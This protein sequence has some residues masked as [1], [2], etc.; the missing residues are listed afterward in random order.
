MTGAGGDAVLRVEDVSHA[1]GSGSE[2]QQVLRDVSFA[3]E[4]G[5]T[6]AVVGESGAGKST[7]SRLVAGLERPQRG[8]IEVEG[9]PTAIRAGRVS[10]VQMAF[11]HPAEALNR[12]ASVG[13]SVQEPL[14]TL[15]RR[16]RH[17]R[18]RELLTQVGIDPGRAGDRP[19]AFSGGQLQRIVLARALVA[20]PALLLCDEPTSA[21]DVSVQ[22]QI[23]NL[24]LRLQAER[25]FACLLVTHD[26]G[27]AKVLCDEVLVLKDGAVVEHAPADAFFAGPQ[28]PYAR[29]LLAATARQM[30]ERPARR[31]VVSTGGSCGDLA[32]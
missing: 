10:P 27:V 12:F 30:L 19:R 31:S 22:A 29:E 21:L 2:R 18:M 8:T 5:R 32:R 4:R 17:E 15:P 13:T 26:L 23:I 6:L 20:Q 9:R 7:L 28:T 14:R 24:L 11:Q 3:L 1:Y 16:E 25:G